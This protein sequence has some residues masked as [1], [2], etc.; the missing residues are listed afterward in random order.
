MNQ[1]ICEKCLLGAES[2]CCWSRSIFT[3]PAANSHTDN[4][5]LNLTTRISVSK[6]DP[7]GKQTAKIEIEFFDWD[8]LQYKLRLISE[9]EATF[10]QRSCSHNWMLTNISD[11]CIF[12]DAHQHS[13]YDPNF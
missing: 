7:D 5:I 12:K 4:I 6:P 13:V 3:K 2:K 1:W 10:R 8:D 9:N 11:P